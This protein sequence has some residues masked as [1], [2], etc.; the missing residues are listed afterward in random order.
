MTKP[1]VGIKLR[2]RYRVQVLQGGV[3]V[4]ERPMADNLVLNQGKD[5]YCGGTAYL[6]ML[7]RYCCVG[8]GTTP[9]T[10][11]DVGLRSEAVRTGT[12][13][14][15]AGN[16]GT[17]YSAGQKVT[18]RRTFDFPVET[19]NR[20]YTE[21]GWSYSGTS[22]N[23]LF[24]RTLI[25]G[26]TVTVLVDQQ[27][28]VVY[29][30]E[31]TLSPTGVQSGSLTVAGWPVAPATGTAGTWEIC[32]YGIA[33]VDTGGNSTEATGTSFEGYV[34]NAKQ[35]RACSALTLNGYGNSPTYTQV[36]SSVAGVWASYTPGSFTRAMVFGYWSAASFSSTGIVGFAA[37]SNNDSQICLAFRFTEAQ[38][39][40]LTHK[41]RPNGY[42]ITVS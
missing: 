26:G 11:A 1:N 40:A 22:G 25:S 13:V 33:T 21:L 39:K 20:N 27:L 42:T 30:L 5:Q 28:R 16:C 17:S 37:A 9:P 32:R 19:V 7:V 15:G 31:V 24:S 35:L 41:L 4:H 29:D 23:N 38:T 14:T 3:L 12:L 34:G 10:T 2:G 18:M 6:N 8:T 36:G